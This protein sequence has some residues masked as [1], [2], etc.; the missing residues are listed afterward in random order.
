MSVSTD[1]TLRTATQPSIDFG[2]YAS[3]VA[4]KGADAKT[5]NTSTKKGTGK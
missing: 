3:R 5:L 2:T 1:K 4:R